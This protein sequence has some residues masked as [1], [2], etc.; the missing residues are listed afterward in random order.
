MGSDD[1]VSDATSLDEWPD[2]SDE[3]EWDG[4]ASVDANVNDDGG[5]VETTQFEGEEEAADVVEDSLHD[6]EEGQRETKEDD[7][8]EELFDG[9]RLTNDTQRPKKDGS[10]QRD[11]AEDEHAETLVDEVGASADGHVDDPDGEAKA[12]PTGCEEGP[13]EDNG[14]PAKS[15]PNNAPKENPFPLQVDVGTSQAKLFDE[16][17]AENTT[18]SES[19][20]TFVPLVAEG[21]TW[22]EHGDDD[23]SKKEE[24]GDEQEHEAYLED[25]AG[26]GQAETN[27]S[28]HAKDT[29]SIPEEESQSLVPGS[30]AEDPHI[31]QA[32]PQPEQ[33]LDTHHSSEISG[34]RD[35][36]IW[37]ESGSV[38]DDGWG[39]LS[40]EE[41]QATTAQ[42]EGG[43]GGWGVYSAGLANGIAS[44]ATGVGGALREVGQG[45]VEDITAVASS[46]NESTDDSAPT[47]SMAAKDAVE[48]L[49]D[50]HS[51]DTKKEEKT[52]SSIFDRLHLQDQSESED[53][54]RKLEDFSHNVSSKFSS[55][56]SWGGGAL[57]SAASSFR[58]EVTAGLAE[59]QGAAKLAG[60]RTASGVAGERIQGVSRAVSEHGQETLDYMSSKTKELLQQQDGG[61]PSQSM[62]LRYFNDFF[63]VSGGER[64]MEDVESISHA[65]TL[66]C[67]KARGSTLSKAK[68]DAS[69]QKLQDILNLG[70]DEEIA[71]TTQKLLQFTGNGLHLVSMCQT[72][73]QQEA[74]ARIEDAEQFCPSVPTSEAVQNFDTSE[75]Q[76]MLLDLKISGVEQLSEVLMLSMKRL[77]SVSKDIQQRDLVDSPE[78]DVLDVAFALRIE[79]LR[80]LEA[81][82]RVTQAYS[83]ALSEVR[84]LFASSAKKTGS[85][86]GPSSEDGDGASSN[87]AVDIFVATMGRFVD[88]M[89]AELHQDSRTCRSCLQD[90]VL[91]LTYV[92]LYTTVAIP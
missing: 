24:S 53:L 73:A 77:L 90:V 55:V 35:D 65:C 2:V 83:S 67:N 16:P 6:A 38:E 12:A 44:V 22:A 68:H 26:Q 46:T 75:E 41:I 33:V 47:Q 34:L 84:E 30:A 80:M 5:G 87:D 10:F 82:E 7:L 31:M 64:A 42:K 81:I 49:R 19:E 20:T 25:R 48:D 62:S 28:T 78:Q 63:Q 61:G 23:Q 74:L 18:A 27:D 40:S 32:D 11:L 13:V 17:A 43:W 58:S 36:D 72:E 92:V 85:L 69:L 56:W 4:S 76:A 91:H 37:N 15:T 88:D 14:S 54:E 66:K 1:D 51:Q 89:T 9:D 8:E 3:D 59:F 79:C 39:E 57:K 45:M 71:S 60:S 86:A 50:S 29:H 70:L 21:G 52:I